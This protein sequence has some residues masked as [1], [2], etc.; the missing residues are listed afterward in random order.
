MSYSPA[1]RT[2]PY[3]IYFPKILP[4]KEQSPEDSIQRNK[5]F[6]STLFRWTRVQRG[7]D[8]ARGWSC[9]SCLKPSR[10][11]SSHL[12]QSEVADLYYDSHPI[13]THLTHHY[14]APRVHPAPTTGAR[15]SPHAL[16]VLFPLPRMPFCQVDTWGPSSVCVFPP[17]VLAG[18]KGLSWACSLL[19]LSLHISIYVNWSP[20]MYIFKYIYILDIKY[21]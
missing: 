9:Y 1:H 12:P 20:Y 10:V 16:A 17:H 15:A 4:L 11:P 21:I 5:G 6:C 13:H 14:R 3:T 18:E 19:A 2:F 8:G 7:S